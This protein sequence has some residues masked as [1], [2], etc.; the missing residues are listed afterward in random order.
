MRVNVFVEYRGS[1][2]TIAEL[3]EL[4]GINR[5]TLYW[6]HKKGWTGDKLTSIARRHT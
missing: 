2:V 1:R 3:A 4:T 6:R 5:I